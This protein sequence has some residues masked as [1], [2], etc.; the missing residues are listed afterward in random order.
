MLRNLWICGVL[1]VT[2]PTEDPLYLSSSS[3]SSVGSVIFAFFA[4]KVESDTAALL[5]KSCYIFLVTLSCHC[6]WL[7]LQCGPSNDFSFCLI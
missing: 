7:L 1:C 5:V 6:H 4:L 3:G 2:K